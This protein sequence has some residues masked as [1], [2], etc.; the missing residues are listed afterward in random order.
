MVGNDRKFTLRT[1]FL[2]S[3]FVVGIVT[4]KSQDRSV[5]IRFEITDAGSVAIGGAKLVL[6]SD[7]NRYE[8]HTD[9]KGLA[10]YWMLFRES[11][12]FMLKTLLSGLFYCN[13][14]YK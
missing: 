5:H 10:W 4:V 1:L 6:S 11:I 9:D 7:A 14:I 3:F 13:F 8:V 2:I 12:R